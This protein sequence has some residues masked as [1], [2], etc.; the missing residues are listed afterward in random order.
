MGRGLCGNVIHG[1]T[2][3]LPCNRK[4]RVV[5]NLHLKMRAPHFYPEADPVRQGA[6]HARGALK[7]SANCPPGVSDS[8]E[9]RNGMQV[10]RRAT[11]GSWGKCNAK[12]PSMTTN[13]KRGVKM[14]ASQVMGTGKPQWLAMRWGNAH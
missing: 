12:Y 14:A 10:T 6:G 8:I 2:R 7:T 5:L 3:I 1:G 13:V 11:E 4:S 9:L